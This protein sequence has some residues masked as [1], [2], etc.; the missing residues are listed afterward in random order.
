MGS[1]ST[2]GATSL[3]TIDQSESK[4]P[5]STSTSADPSPH[6]SAT[7]S[8]SIGVGSSSSGAGTGDAD[9]TKIVFLLRIGGGGASFAAVTAGSGRPQGGKTGGGD[10]KGK[11]CNM[12]TLPVS[13]EKSPNMAHM[14][15]FNLDDIKSGLFLLKRRLQ[16]P[17]S[18][19]I[20]FGARLQDWVLELQDRRRVS[21]SLSLHRP[22][23]P[24]M[25]EKEGEAMEILKVTINEGQGLKQTDPSTQRCLKSWSEGDEEDDEVSVVWEC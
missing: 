2:E 12:G 16:L 18:A 25:E 9:P 1:S 10:E 6:A 23:P 19:S 4:Q 22:M 17:L 15:T 11:A 13:T 24:P 21:I 5:Q 8:R 3:N 14:L 7:H 20:E